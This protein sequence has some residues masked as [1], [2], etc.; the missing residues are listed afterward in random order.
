M[1]PS[2][3][4]VLIC[5]RCMLQTSLKLLLWA[6]LMYQYDEVSSRASSLIKLFKSLGGLLSS[7]HMSSA[8]NTCARLTCMH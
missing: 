6:R 8:R 1:R 2:A 3:E 7:F 4:R 5:L